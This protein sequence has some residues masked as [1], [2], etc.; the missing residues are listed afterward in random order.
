MNSRHR[1]SRDGSRSSLPP[2]SRHRFMPFP[3][4][5]VLRQSK[6]KRRIVRVLPRWK[7]GDGVYWQSTFLIPLQR[8]VHEHDRLRFRRTLS[9]IGRHG[10]ISLGWRRCYC[11]RIPLVPCRW[12]RRAALRIRRLPSQGPSV[13]TTRDEAVPRRHGAVSN[14]EEGFARSAV[15]CLDRHTL[16]NRNVESGDCSPVRTVR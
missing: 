12:G 3:R 15:A 5:E 7:Y 8:A 1:A 9:T 4:E 6:Y 10:S 11:N 14:S 16:L 2:H 13:T